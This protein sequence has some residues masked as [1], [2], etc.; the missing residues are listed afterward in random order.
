MSG[1]VPDRR[2]DGELART[3]RMGIV[4][5]L[6]PGGT[7]SMGAQPDDPAEPRFDPQATPNEGPVHAVTL[8]PYFIAKFELTQSQWLTITGG[9]PGSADGTVSFLA[10]ANP[11]VEGRRGL[12]SVADKTFTVQQNANT[13]AC[14][15]SVAPVDFNPCMP[16]SSVTAR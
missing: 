6:I 1:D 9:S 10:T 7:F 12:I 15:Y 11:K 16:A 8:S 13:A 2:A 3:E 14:Q 4:L 5:V